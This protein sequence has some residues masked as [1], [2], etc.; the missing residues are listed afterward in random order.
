MATTT[1]VTLTCISNIHDQFLAMVPIRNLQLMTVLSPIAKTY[2]PSIAYQKMFLKTLLKKLDALSIE[3]CD[4]LYEE[5][6]KLMTVPD[7]A[8]ENCYRTYT[9]P[10]NEQVTLKESTK[11]ISHGTTGLQTWPAALCLAEWAMQNKH[12]L[13]AKKIVELGCGLGLTGLIICKTCTPTQYVFT[14]YHQQVLR[15]LQENLVINRIQGHHIQDV[16]LVD[17]INS[18]GQIQGCGIQQTCL[19]KET[20]IE[21]VDEIQASD[22]VLSCNKHL[23]AN[24]RFNE[25]P[26]KYCRIQKSCLHRKTENDVAQYKDHS[27]NSNQHVCVIEQC[28]RTL[29]KANC[30]SEEELYQQF[31][32][33]ENATNGITQGVSR[34]IAMATL[35]WENVDDG[36]LQNIQADI[37]L[38]ADVVYDISIVPSL[39]SVLHRFLSSHCEQKQRSQ[40]LAFIASTIRNEETYQGFIETLDKHGIQRRELESPTIPVFY[41]DASC[42]IKLLQLSL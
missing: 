25:N 20:G 34:H 7:S 27:S 3:S 23:G 6:T 33:K 2:P 4:V 12:L 13:D 38:A 8:D 39:V 10:N 24:T 11:L 21:R 36:D 19:H 41:Y 1:E 15:T 40:P 5:Y 31:T 29:C 18:S 14:D 35:D 26:C 42:P 30:K 32:C 9:L 37:I 22:E 17:K 28:G 16:S